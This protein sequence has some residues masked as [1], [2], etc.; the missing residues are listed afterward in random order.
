M[1]LMPSQKTQQII[2]LVT[3]LIV[4]VV[5]VVAVIMAIIGHGQ[6]NV[7]GYP[8]CASFSQI[9]GLEVGS[10]V[11]LA[12]VSVGQVIQEKV[13]PKRFNAVVT[14][15][16]RPD[17]KLPVDTAAIITSDSLLGGKYI[18]LSPGGD[19]TVLKPGQFLTHTQGAISL[20]QLLSKFIFSVTDNMSKNEKKKADNSTDQ[21]HSNGLH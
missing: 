1:V 20:Q 15:T 14:F 19:E 2:E 3:G 10:D 5:F 11:K 4:L 8:L 16:V 7:G 17:V 21:F 6:K 12:G 13:D 18:D 9:D